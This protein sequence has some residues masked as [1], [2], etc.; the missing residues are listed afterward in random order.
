MDDASRGLT[1]PRAVAI[2][3]VVVGL[4]VVGGVLGA[5]V[6]TAGHG[7][8]DHLPEQKGYSFVY[9]PSGTVTVVKQ[10][11]STN[12]ANLTVSGPGGAV[13]WNDASG[14]ATQFSALV[15]YRA[16]GATAGATLTVHER[17]GS[18]VTVAV[19]RSTVPSGSD[20]QRAF[21]LVYHQKPA[22]TVVVADPGRTDT[23]NLRLVG[24]KGSVA[25]ANATFESREDGATFYYNGHALGATAG[26]TLRLVRVADNGTRETVL[27]SQIP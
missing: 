5:R 25:W 10:S 21:E 15:D 17:I 4:L 24:P 1:R 18:N 14:G 13:R 23:S 8:G 11:Y 22:V 9:H 16:L 3:I 26:D 12:P 20:T 6:L 27:T 7:R 19:A 2:G